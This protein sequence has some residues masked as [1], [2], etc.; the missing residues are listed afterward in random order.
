MSCRS[1]QLTELAPANPGVTDHNGR[2]SRDGS[3]A[4]FVIATTNFNPASSGSCSH[5]ASAQASS[6]GN[7]TTFAGC[8]PDAPVERLGG[9]R[10]RNTLAVQQLVCVDGLRLVTNVA[11]S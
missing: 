6:V 3:W 7:A 9:L 1:L 5:G 4:R 11:D 2:S 8:G 10:L